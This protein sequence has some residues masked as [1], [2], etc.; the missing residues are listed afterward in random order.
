M[1]NITA[2]LKNNF[3]IFFILFNELLSVIGIVTAFTAA[4]IDQYDN[5]FL[6]AL[7]LSIVLWVFFTYFVKIPSEEETDAVKKSYNPPAVK[8]SY[9]TEI[10]IRFF[11]KIIIAIFMFIVLLDFTMML[12]ISLKLV[13]APCFH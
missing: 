7:P 10:I 4:K 5:P 3:G 6:T 1:K 11:I 2:V 9:L 12:F 13:V 8:V